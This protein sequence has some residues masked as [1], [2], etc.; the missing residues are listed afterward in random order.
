MSGGICRRAFLYKEAIMNTDFIELL[1]HSSIRIKGDVVI[2]CDPFRINRE[3]HDADLVLITHDHFD[4]F[5]PED[6][7][8]VSKP[9]TVYLIPSVM[10]KQARKALGKKAMILTGDA[11]ESFNFEYTDID[12]VPSYNV[13]KSFHPREAGWVGYLIHIDNKTIY[14]AGDT[15]INDDIINVECDIAMV[16]VGGKYTMDYKEAADLINQIGCNVA[17]PTHYGSVAGDDA[18]G[19]RFKELVDSSIE[20]KI[21]KKY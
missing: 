6:I 9:D 12:M 17:I 18:D 11:G 3:Y 8:L 16:P 10:E 4:H 1:T 13:G 2:Y 15:D 14:I 5:S 20:V 21:I 19:E 7:A